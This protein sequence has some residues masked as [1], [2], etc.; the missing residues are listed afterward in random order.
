MKKEDVLRDGTEGRH[1]HFHPHPHPFTKAEKV[2]PRQN[3]VRLENSGDPKRRVGKSHSKARLTDGDFEGTVYLLSGV[4]L[5]GLGAEGEGQ[6]DR[7]WA[8]A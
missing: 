5:W 7:H 3:S 4:A 6:K 2:R 1:H 8:C